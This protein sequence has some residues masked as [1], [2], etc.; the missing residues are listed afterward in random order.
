MNSSILRLCF[1][2][3]AVGFVASV[4]AITPAEVQQKLSAGEKLTFI[5]V[6]P[7]A[8][9]KQGHIPNAINVPAPVVP[10]KQLPPLG[11]AVVYDEG[12]SPDTA[13]AAAAALNQKVGI[14]A[15]V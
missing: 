4:L 1:C 15:E 3:A 14:A 13:S 2:C 10:H 7:T 8:L 11:R 5:D 9:F 12:L 6:R